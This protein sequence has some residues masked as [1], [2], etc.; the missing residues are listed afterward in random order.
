MQDSASYHKG[1][2]WELAL[3]LR[4]H[5]VCTAGSATRTSSIV[6]YT[7][8]HG[9]ARQPAAS[10]ARISIRV[11]LR[12]NN[13]HRLT[14]RP[15]SVDPLKLLSHY[16]PRNSESKTPRRTSST[17][18]APSVGTI[19]GLYSASWPLAS[20]GRV[21][22]LVVMLVFSRVRNA[23]STLGPSLCHIMCTPST[24]PHI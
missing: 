22:S 18:S 16:S 14:L 20:R 24:P 23:T 12:Q 4:Y 15:V 2:G 5:D 1:H 7:T 21:I 19:C 17:S 10:T 13:I 8:A 3:P 9:P 11:L 6:H